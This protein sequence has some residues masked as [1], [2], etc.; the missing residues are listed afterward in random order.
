MLYIYFKY[1]YSH[2]WYVYVLNQIKQ[3]SIDLTSLE[4]HLAKHTSLLKI[5]ETTSKM[6][7]FVYHDDFFP[8]TSR[9][10][11]FWGSWKRV[12]EWIQNF[13]ELCETWE[14]KKLSV[15]FFSVYLSAF[16]AQI[17]KFVKY[18]DAFWNQFSLNTW[19]RPRRNNFSFLFT[20]Q[21]C[22]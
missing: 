8:G 21:L 2:C 11:S 15:C 1:I 16:R 7:I 14:P 4:H 22:E 9:F 12:S 20:K 3:S 6:S 13:M 5:D 19:R 18:L 17:F 10:R